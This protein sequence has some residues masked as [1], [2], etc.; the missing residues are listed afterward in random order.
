MIDVPPDAY[1]FEG[2]GPK[3]IEWFIGL[4]QDN[5][6]AYF[7]TNRLIFE[8]Q[9][10]DPMLALMMEASTHFGGDI[11]VFRPY[12]DIRFSK[13]KSPY[14]TATYGVVRPETSA[15]G[16]FAS[17]SS[18]GFY[19][20]TGYY[21]IGA[22]QLERFRAAAA[23]EATGPLLETI[24]AKAETNGLTVQGDALKTAPKG[25][26]K[27]HP[28]IRFLRMKEIVAGAMMPIGESLLDRRVFDFAMSTWKTAQPLI[29][30]L[31]TN[32]GPTQLGQPSKFGR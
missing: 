3:A 18:N 30:W 25:Y 32:V 5:S 6:K 7:E 17:I 10:R 23:D 26:P 21:Q 19:A 22:D 13:D 28:R 14:K 20:A 1:R 15:A 27:E 8:E 24:V 9:I 31:D 16:L 12:R 2:F 4:E 11:K 29:A